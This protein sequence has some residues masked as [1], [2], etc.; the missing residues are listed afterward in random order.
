MA[1]SRTPRPPPEMAAMAEKLRYARSVIDPRQVY[2]V[3]SPHGEIVWTGEDL[4]AE[5]EAIVEQQSDVENAALLRLRMDVLLD[6][7]P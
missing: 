3:E 4:L 1:T 7:L 5:V 2:R 6:A